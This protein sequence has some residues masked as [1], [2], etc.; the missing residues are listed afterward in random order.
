MC[1]L[2]WLCS[3][4]ERFPGKRLRPPPMH[5]RL[6]PLHAFHHGGVLEAGGDGGCPVSLV[7]GL[8]QELRGVPGM[9]V[10]VWAL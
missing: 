1:P 4:T 7:R 2:N 8:W 6:R 9:G 5:A 3:R 10:G